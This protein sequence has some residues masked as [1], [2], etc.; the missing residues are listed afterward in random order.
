[1]PN[2]KAGINYEAK[3]D[4]ELLLLVAREVNHHG[5]QLA[6]AVRH[7]KQI[8]GRLGSHDIEI[9]EANKTCTERSKTVFNRL[10]SLEK[11]QTGTNH[12]ARYVGRDVG[13]VSGV[14]FAVGRA[15]GWW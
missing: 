15:A 14:V 13:L 11:V 8:N 1:M 4:R 6:D 5:S 9:A 2:E 3:S 12:Y 10:S 7:L